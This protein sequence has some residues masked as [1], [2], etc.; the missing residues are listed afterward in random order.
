MTDTT[1]VAASKTAVVAII[2]QPMKP[3]VKSSTAKSRSDKECYQSLVLY[4]NANP[5]TSDPS[6][7]TL[8]VGIIQVLIYLSTNLSL[9]SLFRYL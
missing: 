2:N 7:I 8:I 3:I 6:Y 9:L 5:I 1:I 4:N